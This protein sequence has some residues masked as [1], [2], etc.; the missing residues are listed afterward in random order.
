MGIKLYNSLAGKKEELVPVNKG[1]IGMYV[2]GITVYDVCH[3]GHARSA[4]AFDTIRNYLEYKG[5]DV[6]FVKNFTDIDDKIIK[7]ANDEGSDYK[8]ISERYIKE[9]YEDMRVLNIRDAD[10]EPR[11]TQFIDK[12]IDMVAMLVEKGIA[13][14]IDGS[15][16]FEISKFTEY[17]KLSG[18]Q[19][20]E[21][22]AG[23]RVAVDEEK[24]NPLD[25]ALW[26]KSK[27]NEPGWDSP[28]GKGRPGWHIECSV[29][30]M[31]ILG[32]TFDIHGGGKDLVFPHHENE[33]AQSE[34]FSGKPF[35]KYWIHNGFVNI[36]QE[37][38]SKSL[39]NFFT[40]KDILKSYP[41]EALRLF[42]LSTQYRNPIN[43]SEDSIKN[44]C[45]SL[46]RIYTTL[47][48]LK[49]KGVDTDAMREASEKA[50]DK[51]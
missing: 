3:I 20:E 47:A 13:Y 33:I 6:T 36:D 51:R 29:M 10:V 22:Q 25:F 21:L 2:C 44:A 23:A 49:G 15:I 43:F 24:K 19:V 5:F 14:E 27:E 38:M 9:Y 17:G 8:T 48:L 40:I 1:K 46:D 16:Y 37:K 39:G 31:N 4:A 11:A 41:A 7:R 28:W 45:T 34:S 30:G 12:M 26:K 18:K 32:E 50:R 35:V 42:L